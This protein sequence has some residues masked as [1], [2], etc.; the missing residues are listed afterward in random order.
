MTRKRNWAVWVLAALAFVAGLLALVDAARYM[1]WLPIAVLG[2]LKFV[3]PSANWL[4][5][6]LSV[7]IGFIWFGVAKQLY[8]LNPQG[9]LFVVV[10][11]IINLILLGLALLGRSSWS[12]V[13]LGMLVSAAVLVLA[14][15]PGTKTAFGQ[16]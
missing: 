10:I 4:G 1:G 2:D 6:T 13:S 7:L 15:L 3:V 8:D 16:R 5:A 14:L 12:A 9:W 11:A